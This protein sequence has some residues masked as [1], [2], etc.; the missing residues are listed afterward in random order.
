[1]KNHEK[2]WKT[3]NNQPGTMKNHEKPWKTNLKPRK[4]M[5]NHGKLWKT[6][7]KHLKPRKTMKNQPGTMKNHEK[8][9]KTNL[10]PWKTITITGFESVGQSDHF[11]WHTAP[12]IYQSILM[13]IP[14]RSKSSKWKSF[15]LLLQM[16]ALS[17][18]SGAGRKWNNPNWESFLF[19]QSSQTG[20]PKKNSALVKILVAFSKA[21]SYYT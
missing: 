19:L 1:M 6:R 13:I 9:W 16:V 10:E 18:T 4:T 21:K 2:P 7:K 17:P 11:S 12:I 15:T 20:W 5:K 3:M 8:P 14:N